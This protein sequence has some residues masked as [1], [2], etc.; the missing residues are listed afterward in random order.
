MLG[1]LARLRPAT[2]VAITCVLSCIAALVPIWSV[3]HLPL[4]DYPA[5]LA[6]MH[7]L[8]NLAQS[9]ALQNIYEIHWGLLPN[10]AMDIVVPPLSK[11][12]PL[13]D[14][15]RVY[16]SA[17]VVMWITGPLV[18][19]HALFGRVSLWPLIAGYFAYN[20]SLSFGLLNFSFGGGLVFFA[21][22]A[23]IYGQ[24]L[25]RLWLLLLSCLSASTLFFC[26]FI[27]FGAYAI[28]V[29]GYEA[30][31]S[32]RRGKFLCLRPLSARWVLVLAQFVVPAVIF[33]FFSPSVADIVPTAAVDWGGLKGRL[34]AARSTVMFEWGPIDYLVLFFAASV[35]VYAIATRRLTAEPAFLWTIGLLFVVS[36]AMPTGVDGPGLK[37]IRLPPILAVCLFAGTRW[38]DNAGRRAGVIIFALASI[39]LVTRVGIT[40][41]RW[42]LQDARITE[43]RQASAK[44]A[45][46]SALFLAPSGDSRRGLWRTDLDSF[47]P[48]LH[49]ADY[50]IIDRSAFT[51]SV[52]TDRERQPVW[53]TEHYWSNFGRSRPI[54]AWKAVRD[55]R[56]TLRYLKMWPQKYDYVTVVHFGQ[57]DMKVPAFLTILHTGSYFTIFEID[58]AKV[59]SPD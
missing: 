11:I 39:L 18:L 42:Q 43:F 32:F 4:I 9:P 58:K 19:H 6:R 41:D 17:I 45:E 23:W 33:I 27:A 51:P 2:A 26:H 21:L 5:H 36:L 10:L 49:I 7:I 8:A 46:G 56:S 16:V 38:S 14:A 24:K 22:A 25:P 12:I 50:T 34:S 20:E 31:Q 54:V 53:Q 59:G 35:F 29:V 13:I 37:H 44:I 40:T 52:F 57:Q 55:R 30:G 48:F 15:G 1:D 28:A 3:V 47:Y